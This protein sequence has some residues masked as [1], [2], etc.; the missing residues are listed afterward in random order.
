MFTE[1][2]LNLLRYLRIAA[3]PLVAIPAITACSAAP[4][5]EPRDHEYRYTIT[6]KLNG[7]YILVEHTDIRPDLFVR[8]D[9]VF[10]LV[11]KNV[12]CFGDTNSLSN[13]YEKGFSCNGEARPLVNRLSREMIQY[14]ENPRS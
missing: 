2:R 8:S 11:A 7:D 4:R 9:G 12:V 6:T 1:A 5:A 14:Q 13:N 10:Q 3:L